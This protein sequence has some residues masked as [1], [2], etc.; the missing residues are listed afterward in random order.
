MHNTATVSSSKTPTYNFSAIVEKRNSHDVHRFGY[1]R[2]LLRE[3]RLNG[4]LLF[5]D[6]VWVKDDKRTSKLCPGDHIHFTARIKPYLDIDNLKSKKLGLTML[7]NI[8]CLYKTKKFKMNY[9]HYIPRDKLKNDLRRY[10]ARQEKERAIA[11][12]R[13][14]NLKS[15]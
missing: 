2:I 9:D 7:R 11:I 6:H 13:K 5:R 1:V 15:A 4:N 3:V 14:A 10:H 8:K 12:A